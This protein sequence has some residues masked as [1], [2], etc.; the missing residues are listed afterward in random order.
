VY[1]VSVAPSFT[2]KKASLSMRLTLVVHVDD[3]AG[4]P[5]SRHVALHRPR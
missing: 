2:V 5:L 3:S 4:T 1:V